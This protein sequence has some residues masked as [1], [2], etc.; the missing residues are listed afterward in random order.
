MEEAE[1]EEDEEDKEG[2]VPGLSELEGTELAKA[3][4]T[5]QAARER[6]QR[7]LERAGGFQRLIDRLR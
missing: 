2:G 3:V 4:E 1:D 7:E 5:Q 6:S